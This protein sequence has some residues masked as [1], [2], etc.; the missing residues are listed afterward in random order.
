MILRIS[1]YVK[2][3]CSVIY[4]IIFLDLKKKIVK[5]KQS[6]KRRRVRKNI[7][8][9]NSYTFRPTRRNTRTRRRRRTEVYLPRATADPSRYVIAGDDC[10]R[11]YLALQNRF[12][13]DSLQTPGRITNRT[14]GHG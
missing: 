8:S 3:G 9:I 11:V 14:Y 5:V 7:S 2:F 10:D 13:C 6:N 1:F 4:A 12:I